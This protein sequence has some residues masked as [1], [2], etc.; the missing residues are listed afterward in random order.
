MF[1]FFFSC[2]MAASREAGARCMTLCTVL[3]RVL[4][5]ESVEHAVSEA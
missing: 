2:C 5:C 3:G 4:F 1:C